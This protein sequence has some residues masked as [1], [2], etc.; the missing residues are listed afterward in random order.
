MT[1]LNQA[2]ERERLEAVLMKRD[3]LGWAVGIGR[4]VAGE[5][6]RERTG[7]MAEGSALRAALILSDRFD[8]LVVRT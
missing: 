8:L 7:H 5:I 2:S 3:G 4:L 1:A 6:E